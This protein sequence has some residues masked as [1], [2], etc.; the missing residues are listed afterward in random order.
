MQQDLVVAMD[1]MVMTDLKVKKDKKEQR[2]IWQQDQPVKKEQRVVP[3]RVLQ[4]KVKSPKQVIYHLPAIQKGDAYI[5]QA[6]DSLHIWDG[7]QWVSGGSIQGPQGDKG[8]KGQT[9]NTGST[10]STGP[11]GSKGQ[12]GQTGQPVQ[13]VLRVVMDPT[14]VMVPKVRRVK[15]VLRVPPEAMDQMDP[16]EVRVRR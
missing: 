3:V 12:K 13:R 7:T 11:T 6:D 14:E 10:G 15:L 8:Q 1:P 2:V 9:G 16:M 4:W 5:V